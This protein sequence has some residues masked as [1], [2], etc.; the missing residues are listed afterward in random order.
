MKE[1]KTRS[2]VKT[3]G[4]RITGSFSTFIISYLM[5]QNLTIAGTIGLVQI[6]INTVLYYMYER[7]WNNINWGYYT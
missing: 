3:I 5:I 2:L 1:S 6:I 4:W 7:L